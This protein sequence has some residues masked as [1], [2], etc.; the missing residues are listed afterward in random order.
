MTRGQIE[1]TGHFIQHSFL[2]SAVAVLQ[3]LGASLNPQHIFRHAQIRQFEL[4]S[5]L[6]EGFQLSPAFL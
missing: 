6:T 3:T 5:L 2:F 4:I 1:G